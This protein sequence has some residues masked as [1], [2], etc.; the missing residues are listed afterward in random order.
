MARSWLDIPADSGFGL[1]NLPYGVISYADG[2]PQPAV[3][4]SR[5]V[6]PLGAAAEAGLFDGVVEEPTA[7]LAVPTLNPLMSAGPQ[8]WRAVRT[9]IVDLFE[10]RARASVVQPLLLPMN[11]VKH[12][13]P[14]D[15]ADYVDFF[16]SRPHAENLGRILR[17]D[18]TP[19][20]PNWT[21]LPVGCHGRSASVVVSGTP[22]TRPHGQRIPP[23]DTEPVFGPTIRLDLE[24]ELG[25]IVGVPTQIGQTVPVDNFS[26]HVFGVVLVNDWTARDIQA[27]E[28]QPLGP[29]LGKSFAT[30]IS[31]WVVP[32]AALTE[33]HV[34]P[35]H[36]DPPPLP[37]LVGDHWGYDVR[38]RVEL[39][40]TAIS[41]PPFASLYWTPA[42]QLAH[43]TSNGSPLRTGD[44]FASGAVSGPEPTQLGSLVELTWN[45]TYPLLLADGSTRTFLADGDTV[46]ISA[47]A[48][49]P[50]ST[51]IDFGSVTG[52]IQSR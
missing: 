36:Q 48:P 12:H 18:A 46:S 2:P 14:F 51:R 22:V 27:W 34:A 6:F 50:D 15:V 28:H 25:F 4:V 3:A 9:R 7:V 31:P 29:L 35:P 30:S 32:L 39:N 19:L 40:D 52:T 45:G 37:H 1:T 43:L 42:Q 44:L 17:P 38:L 26:D 20:P 49:G 8:V 13:L 16:S 47:S 41:E 5:Y 11:R 21:H 10:S 33:A 23:T 24:A